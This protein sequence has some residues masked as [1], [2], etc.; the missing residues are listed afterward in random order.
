MKR[1][2]SILLI[3]TL[4]LF[5]A[6]CSS[7]SSI[8]EEEYQDMQDPEIL[9]EEIQGN[10]EGIVTGETNL[11]YDILLTLNEDGEFT[12]QEANSTTSEENEKLLKGEYEVDGDQLILTVEENEDMP[13]VFILGDVTEFTFEISTNSLKLTDFEGNIINLTREGIEAN[14]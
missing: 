1:L 13:E 6:G 14:Q 12:Y 4:I 3:F 8:D 2:F 10:W 9:A 11:E 5:A 7:D